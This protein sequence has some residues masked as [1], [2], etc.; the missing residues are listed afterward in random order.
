VSFLHSAERVPA[1]LAKCAEGNLADCAASILL[2]I[3][4]PYTAASKLSH[5]LLNLRRVRRWGLTTSVFKVI[6]TLQHGT[7]LSNRCVGQ[8][9]TV[10]HTNS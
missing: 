5:Q 3:S 8:T 6:R 7:R 2:R 4:S 9:L 10:G 1:G